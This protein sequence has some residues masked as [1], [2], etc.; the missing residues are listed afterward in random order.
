MTE[1][2]SKEIV[3]VLSNYDTTHVFTLDA[4]D[5]IFKLTHYNNVLLKREALK[6]TVRACFNGYCVNFSAYVFNPFSFWDLYIPH[7]ASNSLLKYVNILQNLKK[8]KGMSIQF[9][10]YFVRSMVGFLYYAKY[11]ESNKTE[12][13]LASKRLVQK[14]LNLESS[15]IKLRSAKFFLTNLKYSKSIEI[16]DTFLTF[17]PRYQMHCY[18]DYIVEIIT[19]LIGPLFKGKTTEGIENVMK[20]I[21]PMFYS[22]VE[23]K[24][25]PA[26]YD[27]TQQNPVWIFRSFTNIFFHGLYMDAIFMTAEQW[28]VPDPIQYEL[29]SLLPN[30]DE[31]FPF[32]GIHLDPIFVRF[33][34]RL[35]C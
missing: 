29:L 7:N 11:K 25:F 13:V 19:K 18:G 21:L 14:S 20:A 6:S 33:L 4:F 35:F 31:E 8:L 10:K 2:L 1:K 3:D 22:S 26:N 16:C 28:V 32:S 12:F 9:S 27:I 24:S 34:I 17:T 15:C 5:R 30:A 23:L